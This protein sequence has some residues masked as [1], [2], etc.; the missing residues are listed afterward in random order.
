MS[1]IAVLYRCPLNMSFIRAPLDVLYACP[2]SGRALPLG[3]LLK[4]FIYIL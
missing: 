1:F 4:T 3:K 2:L